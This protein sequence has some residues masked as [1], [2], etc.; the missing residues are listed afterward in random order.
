MIIAVDYFYDFC[1]DKIMK[2]DILTLL[3]SMENIQN[4]GTYLET[5]FKN[6]FLK[7]LHLYNTY[8]ILYIRFVI[9][10]LK[11]PDRLLLKLN[12]MLLDNFRQ[13]NKDY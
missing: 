6:V 11:E 1:S 9:R 3:C 8:H 5:I 4:L 7:V 13:S 2:I 10:G 12:L